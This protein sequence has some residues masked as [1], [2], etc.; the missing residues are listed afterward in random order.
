MEGRESRD[1]FN[2][3]LAPEYSDKYVLG[4]SLL[5]CTKDAGKPVRFIPPDFAYTWEYVQKMIPEDKLSW[6][7]PRQTVADIARKC[8]VSAS[9]YKRFQSVIEEVCRKI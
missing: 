6:I 8:N 2:E 3:S 4:S 7:N 1:T 9:G 5:F